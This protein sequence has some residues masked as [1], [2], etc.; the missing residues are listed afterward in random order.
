MTG[1]GLAQVTSAKVDGRWDRVYAGPSEMQIPDDFLAALA[2]SPKA[3]QT[4]DSLNKQNLYA[5]Y[6]RLH[7]ARAPG[8]RARKI[9]ALIATLDRGER[10]HGQRVDA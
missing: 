1:P 2:L 9:A 4:F 10:F 8:G 3:R 5:I 7:S 6:Y